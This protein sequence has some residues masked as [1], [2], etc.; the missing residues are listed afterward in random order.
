VDAWLGSQG[1][2][3]VLLEIGRW[4][5]EPAAN[6]ALSGGAELR[7]RIRA[8][9]A[10]GRIVAYRRE[11]VVHAVP[12]LKVVPLRRENVEKREEKTWIGIHLVDDDDPPNPIPYKKYRVTLPD[13]S[14]REGML[15]ENGFARLN[16]VDPGKCEVTFPDLDASDWKQA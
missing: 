14:E 10:E 9:L 4:L 3:P 1:A 5:G 7:A 16:G 12:V 2:R 8:A 15:D 6:G 13:H 11:S